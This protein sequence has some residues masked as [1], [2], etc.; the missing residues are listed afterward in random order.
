MPVRVKRVNCKEM[1]AELI[2]QA[3][4]A[5]AAKKFT[6]GLVTEAEKV[7]LLNVERDK[8]FRMLAD[9]ELDGQSL[10]KALIDNGHA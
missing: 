7:I 9:V 1:R 10:A 4:A 2:S 6:E 8:Y 5:E 3:E